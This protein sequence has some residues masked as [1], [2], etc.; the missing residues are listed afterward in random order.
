MPSL[1]NILQNKGE[2]SLCTSPL[3]KFPS[4]PCQL[5][6]DF[7]GTKKWGYLAAFPEGKIAAWT[8]RYPCPEVSVLHIWH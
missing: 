3:L 7:C 1:R 8:E 4:F 5:M 2:N 6:Q